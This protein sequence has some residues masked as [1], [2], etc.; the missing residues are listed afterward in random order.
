MQGVM[1]RAIRQETGD[2]NH[3][4]FYIII[5]MQNIVLS[6]RNASFKSYS[7]TIKDKQEKHLNTACSAI[8]KLL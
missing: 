6:M 2:Y 5:K 7:T 8:V 4:V 3:I 1:Q